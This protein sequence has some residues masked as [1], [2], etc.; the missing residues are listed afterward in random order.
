MRCRL[1]DLAEGVIVYLSPGALAVHN[2]NLYVNRNYIVDTNADLGQFLFIRISKRDGVVYADVETIPL[3]FTPPEIN[4][5]ILIAEHYF[6]L[7]LKVF[8]I[9][10]LS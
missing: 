9:I 1:K 2:Q 5:P 7:E 4:N 6:P 10:S 3:N 8:V